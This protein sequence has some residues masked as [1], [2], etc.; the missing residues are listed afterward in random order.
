MRTAVALCLVV[1]LG[2]AACSRES[3]SVRAI[4]SPPDTKLPAACREVSPDEAEALIK[5][6]PAL[7]LLDMRVETEWGAEGHISGA[8]LTN[9]FRAGL[10]EHLATMP[11]EKPHLVYCALGER[12]RQ[13]AAMMGELGFK[14]IYVLA[15]G[16]DAWKAAAKP[17]VK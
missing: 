3:S 12:S 13:T 14:E 11:R 7:V 15:G 2:V 5:T 6:K 17:V 16:L 8:Q 4:T 9:F 1:S 10:R